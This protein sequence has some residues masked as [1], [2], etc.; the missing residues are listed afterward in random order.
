M[1]VTYSELEARLQVLESILNQQ[2]STITCSRPQS[3]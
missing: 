2:R 3:P 1:T